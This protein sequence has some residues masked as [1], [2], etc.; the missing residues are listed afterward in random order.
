[1][2]RAPVVASDR[3]IAWTEV[4]SRGLPALPFPYQPLPRQLHRLIETKSLQARK[5]KSQQQLNV[6]FSKS[7]HLY[8][9]NPLLTPWQA[10]LL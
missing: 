4:P 2:I 10:R 1:M 3:G 9:M 6:H 5:L 8:L 7:L